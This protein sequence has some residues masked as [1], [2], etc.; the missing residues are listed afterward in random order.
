MSQ[1]GARDQSCVGE[2][3]QA[4]VLIEVMSQSARPN[5]PPGWFYTSEYTSPVSLAYDAWAQPARMRVPLL[6]SGVGGEQEG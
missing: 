6:G 1:L 4:M 5:S 2:T 3:V